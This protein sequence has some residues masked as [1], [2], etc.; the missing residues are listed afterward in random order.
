M[1]VSGN[2]F[3]LRL[4]RRP[5]IN[6]FLRRTSSNPSTPSSE[7]DQRSVE[8]NRDPRTRDARRTDRTDRRLAGVDFLIES[9]FNAGEQFEPA[10]PA[11]PGTGVE[12]RAAVQLEIVAI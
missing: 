4:L 12:Q 6:T 9:V 8:P 2:P 10:R 7:K 11:P 3:D 5:D 1:S